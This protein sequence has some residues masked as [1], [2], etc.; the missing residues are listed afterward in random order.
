MHRQTG[1][2]TL[3]VR[4]MGSLVMSTQTLLSTALICSKTR[5]SPVSVAQCG[6]GHCC[7]SLSPCC[8]VARRVFCG[9]AWYGCFSPTMRPGVSTQSAT[10][11]AGEISRRKI[12]AATSGLWHCWVWVKAGTTITMRFRARLSTACTGGRLISQGTSSG[13]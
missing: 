8:L 10:H 12:E 1:R 4:S 11:L 7:H 3:I 6:S 5:L 13:C 2:V 9:A